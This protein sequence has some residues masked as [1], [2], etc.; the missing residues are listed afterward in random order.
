MPDVFLRQGEGTPSDLRL[1]AS[2]AYIA[3][4][5]A[6]AQA[7]QTMSASGTVVAAAIPVTPPAVTHGAGGKRRRRQ[8]ITEPYPL[9]VL[10][11]VREPQAITGTVNTRQSAQLMRATGHVQQMV[12][13]L[14]LTRQAPQMTDAAGVVDTRRRDERDLIEILMLLDAA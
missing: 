11:P 14:A 12:K 6:T 5:A 7:V 2:I 13:G 4:I 10:W 1:R 9:R 8:W 3:G